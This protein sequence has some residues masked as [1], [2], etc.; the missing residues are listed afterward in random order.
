M[1][2]DNYQHLSISL[3]EQFDSLRSRAY[4]IADQR[5]HSVQ[6]EGTMTFSALN[7]FGDPFDFVMPALLAERANV[8]QWFFHT[9]TAATPL[10]SPRI[11]RTVSGV[12]YLDEG[13]YVPIFQFV[14]GLARYEI[15]TLQGARGGR[16]AIEFDLKEAKGAFHGRWIAK[17][18]AKARL[19]KD[20]GLE[21]ERV[22]TGQTPTT[23]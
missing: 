2:E 21:L 10:T 16:P 11:G 12:L 13:L 15:P 20:G 5:G 17:H 4:D 7:S 18:V 3:R 23:K 6:F 9:P 1:R 8:G 22:A 19:L 14:S